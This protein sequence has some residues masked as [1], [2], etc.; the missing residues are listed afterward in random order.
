MFF[1][2]EMKKEDLPELPLGRSLESIIRNTAPDEII[3]AYIRILSTAFLQSTMPV[4]GN[5]RKAHGRWQPAVRSLIWSSYA[6]HHEKDY[7]QNEH[8]K[9]YHYAVLHDV[10]LSTSHVLLLFRTLA[11]T[12]PLAVRTGIL[13]ADGAR[14]HPPC[15][16]S[17]EKRTYSTR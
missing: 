13:P 7:L 9:L 1:C 8:Y 14:S 6:V 11:A 3:V 4:K 15:G 2:G 5:E 10:V 17:A 12:L 16:M